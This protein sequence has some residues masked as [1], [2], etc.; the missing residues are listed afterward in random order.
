MNVPPI[1]ATHVCA[2]CGARSQ[3]TEGKCWLCF[4]DKGVANPY[5]V[6]PGSISSGPQTAVPPS[7]DWDSFFK[8]LLLLCIVLTVLIAVGLG[9]QDTG[10]LIPFAIVVG[11][12]YI[13]TIV[14][15][16]AQVNS[17]K[18]P[19]AS[20]LFL[21]FMLSLMGTIAVFVILAVAAIIFLFIV[22]LQSINR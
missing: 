4:G 15:G 8:V 3:S 6:S 19:K 1:I 17:E 16:L 5:A 7:S 14:R 18:G 9:V 2:N 10:M 21:T 12:A 20:S 13:V 11:P 22:C